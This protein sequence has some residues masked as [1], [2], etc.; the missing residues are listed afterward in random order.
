[1]SLVGLQAVIERSLAGASP[2]TKELFDE[3]MD[4]PALRD[5]INQVASATVATVG[6]DDRPHASLT[7]VAC[8]NSGDLYIAVNRRSALSRNLKR[9]PYVAITVD[10]SEHGLMAQ[11]KAVLAGMAP[12]LRETLMPELDAIMARGRWV[13][14]DWDGAVYRLELTRIFGR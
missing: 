8:S 5:F 4:A 6:R 12:D 1:M 11:G 9:S 3:H 13:P 2:L 14:V 10:A 7:L